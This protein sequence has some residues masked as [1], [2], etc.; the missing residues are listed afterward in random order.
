MNFFITCGGGFQAIALISELR[1]VKGAKLFLSDWKEKNINKFEVDVFFL[2]PAISDADAYLSFLLDKCHR[3]KI[4]Y[5]IPATSLDIKLL[6]SNK[7]LF[8]RCGTVCFLPKMDFLQM[9]LDK[10]HWNSYFST[11]NIQKPVVFEPNNEIHFPIIVKERDSWGG[12]GLVIYNTPE[13]FASYDWNDESLVMEYISNADEYSLDFLVST[14]G[15]LFG[16]ICRRREIVSGGFAV[17]SAWESM[18]QCIIKQWSKLK[19]EFE[20]VEKMGYYNVQFLVKNDEAYL[21]DIN[22]RIG[23]SSTISSSIYS[24]GL[25][26]SSLSEKELP[27]LKAEEGMIVRRIQDV[28]LPKKI[29]TNVKLILFDLDDTL[30]SN[31]HF[32]LKRCSELYNQIFK[33]KYSRTEFIGYCKMLISNGRAFELID[34]II[35]RFPIQCEKELVLVKYRDILP[36][37]TEVFP[38]VEETLTYLLGK[39]YELAIYSSSSNK[40]IKHKLDTSCLGKYFS[41][42]YSSEVGASGDKSS[43][44]IVKDIIRE[45]GLQ[46]SQL[47]MIGDNYFE[48]IMGGIESGCQA[49]FYIPCKGGMIPEVDISEMDYLDNVIF[50]PNLSYIRN[51]L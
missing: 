16:P 27:I 37:E 5:V 34:R 50:L 12:R 43:F 25:M 35:A 47:V 30:I 23:T 32:I 6:S 2:A 9:C 40:L 19:E 41:E 26:E 1:K 29:F 39:G 3:E 49:A 24:N 7:D 17:V 28:V 21:I 8:L 31:A 44:S 42:Y 51:Y 15:K 38:R 45:R 13:S 22:P 18:P 11:R 4:D 20:H 14:S 10:A 33:E 36:T 46:M 48:D